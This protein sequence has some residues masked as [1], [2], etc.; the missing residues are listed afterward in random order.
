ME[1]HS[2]QFVAASEAALTIESLALDAHGVLMRPDA[3][4]F[5]Y[6]DGDA[7]EDALLA[8][9][10]ASADRSV[11]SDELRSRIIDWPSRYHLSPDRANLLRHLPWRAG[12]RVLEIGAGCGAITRFLGETGAQVLAVE[13]S[14]RRARTC[15][16]RCAELSNVQVACSDIMRLQAQ[17]RFDVVTLIGVLEYA[18]VYVGGATP[19]LDLLRHAC[20]FLVPGGRLLI[21]IENRLGLKYFAGCREDHLNQVFAGIEDHY[22][23]TSVRTF[24]RRELQSLLHDAGFAHTRFDY[25]YPDYKLPRVMLSEAAVQAQDFDAAALVR[26]TEFEDYGGARQVVFDEFLALPAIGRNGLLGELSNSFLVLAGD[27][28]LPQPSALAHVYSTGRSVDLAARLSFVRGDKAIDAIKTPLGEQPQRGPLALRGER[29]RY[30]CAPTL[31][32]RI[33]EHARHR[34]WDAVRADFAAYDAYLAQQPLVF[35]SM[36]LDLRVLAGAGFDLTPRNLLAAENGLHEI[37]RE[38]QVAFDIAACTPARRYLRFAPQL[39]ALGPAFGGGDGAQL[40]HTLM[41]RSARR[42][43]DAELIAETLATERLIATAYPFLQHEPDLQPDTATVLNL[44]QRLLDNGHAREA[45]RT[46]AYAFF[47]LRDWHLANDAALLCLTLGCADEGVRLYHAALSLDADHRDAIAQRLHE[48][49][50]AAQIDTPATTAAMP[51][52]PEPM[53]TS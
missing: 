42:S 53:A 33:V 19:F 28:P 12:D 4:P 9:L 5:A 43:G 38:W 32:Q 34:Q 17:P 10:A 14:T 41:P 39:A 50:R 18:A 7:A 11:A 31:H 6:S 2:Q 45:A 51:A 40:L 52:S 48:F 46:L 27:A 23:N 29:S 24:G 1:H 26:E 16:L 13:G 47:V 20:G 25:P 37:D 8:A 36:L 49:A 35:E 3:A 30:R 15:R 44:A 21:A 22:T